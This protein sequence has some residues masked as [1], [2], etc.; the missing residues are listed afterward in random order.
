[1]KIGENAYLWDLCIDSKTIWF[2][3]SR[4]SALIGYDM[5]NHRAERVVPILSEEDDNINE[6]VVSGIEKD[7]DVI[8]LAP[9]QFAA[10]MF[11]NV[12]TQGVRKL[13][14][15]TNNK[16][17]PRM[18]MFRASFRWKGK[19]YL[20]PSQ[21]DSIVSVDISKMSYKKECEWKKNFH[22]SDDEYVVD[23]A[24]DDTKLILLLKPSNRILVYSLESGEIRMLPKRQTG[25]VD[26]STL[27]LVDDLIYIKDDGNS[28]LIYNLAGELI[29]EKVDIDAIN[30][31]ILL[32]GLNK[33]LFVDCVMKNKC[34]LLDSQLEHKCV[35]EDGANTFGEKY[36]YFS[37]QSQIT[38]KEKYYYFNNAT[39]EL[40]WFTDTGVVQR[41]K[42][43]L[44]T[45]HAQLVSGL[46]AKRI[47]QESV[48]CPF[49]KWI[50]EIKQDV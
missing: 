28:I 48:Y 19:C 31:V 40:I 4:Y 20:V 29:K 32:Y 5:E 49:D 2:F 10:I 45:I 6:S 30:D 11:V 7:G 9:N 16:T 41:E 14:M 33:T 47:L 25:E 36:V 22:F 42:I 50:K 23:Y 39:S 17:I 38:S 44:G 8:M 13:N 46:C 12:A 15:L 34:F 1:M 27:A 18:G 3:H 21:Y 43:D 35:I 26:Y 24:L 37:V